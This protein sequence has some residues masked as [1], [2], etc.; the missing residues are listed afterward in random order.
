MTFNRILCGESASILS[1]FQPN[2][3]DLVITDP[4]YLCN[5]QDRHGRKIANDDN[6][7]ATLSVF[8]QIYRVMKPNS[9]CISFYG[10]G[11][12]DQF[13]SKWASLGFNTVGH[14]VW[15]KRYASSTT[16][17]R[18]KTE[19]AF[20]LTKG[21]PKRPSNPISNVQM[22]QYTGN[23]L[24]PTEKAV[25]IIKPLVKCF[26]KPGDLVLDPFSGSGTTAIAAALQDRQYIGIELEQ[27]YCEIAR[28]RLA[29]VEYKRTSSSK[30]SLEQRVSASPM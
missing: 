20:I 8:D 22:W 14:I 19:A 6:P 11:A 9:Y 4:P 16:F 7:N 17:T 23:K 1:H 26:S 15:A 28:K 13:A 10:W 12:I 3:V 5:Y 2:M 21:N 30:H 24:H 18:N 29:S 27:R 25:S